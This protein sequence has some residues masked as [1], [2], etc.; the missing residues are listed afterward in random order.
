[1]VAKFC[2]IGVFPFILLAILTNLTSSSIIS[3]DFYEPK[4]NF[5]EITFDE[6]LVKFNKNYQTREEINFRRQVF[7]TNLV[8]L[9]EI[10]KTC[11]SCGITKY[12][13]WTKE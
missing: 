10:V 9:R 6:Y 5:V 13:D 4:S 2:R 1:M 12:T 11:K 8:E 7:E 3:S